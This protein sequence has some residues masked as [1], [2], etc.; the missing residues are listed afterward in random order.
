MSKLIKKDSYPSIEVWYSN[1]ERIGMFWILNCETHGDELN[2][3][4]KSGSD[5]CLECI[6]EMLNPKVD[7][8][9]R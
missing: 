8:D 9:K 2:F 5:Y 4:D 7:H 6:K 3:T 1:D